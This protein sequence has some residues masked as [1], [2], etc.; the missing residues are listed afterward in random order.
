[1]IAHF[2]ATDS[3]L[4]GLL[5][6]LLVCHIF[7]AIHDVVSA[8]NSERAEV[9]SKLEDAFTKQ[10]CKQEN[11]GWGEAFWGIAGTPSLMYLTLCG[12]WLHCAAGRMHATSKL[13]A[14]QNR[15]A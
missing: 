4:I 1:M 2:I 7:L 13:S 5:D 12:P 9:I 14:K 3:L 15:E 11:E 10:Q 6:V 8:K